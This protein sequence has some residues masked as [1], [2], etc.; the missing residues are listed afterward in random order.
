MRPS[1]R[2]LWQLILAL[3]FCACV[4]WAVAYRSLPVPP[5]PHNNHPVMSRRIDWIRRGAAE[6]WPSPHFGRHL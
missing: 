6:Y 3:L 2:T 4:L 5:A 1:N